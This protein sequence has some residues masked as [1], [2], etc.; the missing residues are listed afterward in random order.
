MRAAGKELSGMLTAT[1][2]FAALVA[3]WARLGRR[4]APRG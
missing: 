2:L 3:L 4:G 1:I